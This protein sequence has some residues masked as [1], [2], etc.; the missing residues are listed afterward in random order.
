MKVDYKKIK[1]QQ[2]KKVQLSR[3][4]DKRRW[5]VYGVI[6]LACFVL[7]GNTLPFNYAF[8]DTILITGNRFVQKGISGIPEILSNDMFTG[9]YGKNMNMVVG[10]RYRPLSIVTFAVEYH[11]LGENPHFSRVMNIFLYGLTGILIYMLFCYVLKRKYF[12]SYW[13]FSVPFITSML[14]VAHPVHTEVVAN[15]KGRDEI[16]S[17]LGSML[18]LLLILKYL[19]TGKFKYLAFG[20]LAFFL[21]LMSKENTITFLAVIPLTVFFFTDHN[22]KKKF[23]FI[24]PLAFVTIIF[25]IIRQS[26]IH[27]G[28]TGLENDLMNNPFVEMNFIQKYATIFYTLGLY[29]KLLF[30][31]YPLTYDY[32]PYHIPIVNITDLQA[33]IPLAVYI[34]LIITAILGFRRKSN[35]SFGILYFIIT[36][37]VVSNLLFPIG[38]FM[39]ER[40]IYMSS[41]GYC[42]VVASLLIDGFQKIIASKKLFLSFSG[43]ILVI[44]LF[45]FYIR[46]THRNLDWESSFKLFT[47]DVKVSGNSAKGNSLAG[48]YLIYAAKEAKDKALK[49]QYLKEALVYLNK[50]VE[51]YPRH[52]LALFNIAAAHYELDKNYDEIVKAY[53]RLLDINPNG[54]IIFQNLFQVFGT[55]DDTDYKLKVLYDF[56]SVNPDR[57]DLTFQIGALLNK[58]GEYAKAS[59]YLEKAVTMKNNDDKAWNNLGFSYARMNRFDKALPAFQS[60]EKIKPDDAQIIRNIAVTW[61][62]LGNT[63]MANEYFNKEKQLT[64][65]KN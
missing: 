42:F 16:L 57:F 62:N 14:F 13:Y 59:G 52:V 55:L 50:A 15:I 47:T 44:Y 63:K 64:A 12:E 11:L 24:V 56:Y 32:Y 39:N 7:Y 58:K 4:K 9:Y 33:L 36:I 48:E 1:K 60:A 20:T 54:D 35:V 3:Q 37:S 65:K 27:V 21:G 8:D 38:A 22:L 61:Q 2:P 25:L 49:E 10:G 28:K 30:F 46:T 6:M 43:S 34:M 40:F 18:T 23:S 5:I 41:V 17:L 26:T 45:F 29:I 51:I 31:P 53:R 19:D